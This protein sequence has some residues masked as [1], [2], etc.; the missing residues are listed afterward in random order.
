M[1]VP[2]NHPFKMENQ[3][4][5]RFPIYGSFPIYPVFFLWFPHFAHEGH[6][7]CICLIPNQIICKNLPKQVINILSFGLKMGYSI[8]RIQSIDISMG[9]AMNGDTQNHMKLLKCH[10]KSHKPLPYSGWFSRFPRNQSETRH[11]G[12]CWSPNL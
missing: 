2:L 6:I 9:V 10:G 12:L 1:G 3:A 5:W 4:F 7:W 11:F 8:H